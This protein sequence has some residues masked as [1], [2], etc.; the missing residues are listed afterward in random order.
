MKED[1]KQQPKYPQIP[2]APAQL[3]IEQLGH[4]PEKVR[5]MIESIRNN[6]INTYQS[7]ENSQ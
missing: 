5:D 6:F 1:C 2:N 7:S 3:T 4:E